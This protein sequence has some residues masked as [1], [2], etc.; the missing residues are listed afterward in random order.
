MQQPPALPPAR[1]L[2]GG[3]TG[4]H[5]AAD[6]RLPPTSQPPQLRHIPLELRVQLFALRR[7]GR[8]QVCLRV[9]RGPHYCAIQPQGAAK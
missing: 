3:L 7:H 2:R 4:P 9:R 8:P 1:L 6:P 5:A